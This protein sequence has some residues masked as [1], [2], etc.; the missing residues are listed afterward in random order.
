MKAYMEW[1]YRPTF[2]IL[3]LSM[4]LHQYISYTQYNSI[5]NAT[6][7]QF[8]HNWK[9]LTMAV[10]SRNMSRMEGVIEIYSSIVDRII[11]CVRDP[12]F[13]DLGTSWM[14]MVS[15]TPQP[16]CP[17]GDSTLYTLDI[18]L[19][20][21][22]G[23]YEWRREVKILVPTAT[24]NSNPFVIQPTASHYTNCAYNKI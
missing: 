24:Q 2:A 16:L 22:Q 14:W 20:E 19:R 9:H 5:N 10:C 15:F 17:Q 4:P 3:Y 13:L 7:E 21:P 8:W 23:Q 18:R 11:L 6:M 12:S 1:M